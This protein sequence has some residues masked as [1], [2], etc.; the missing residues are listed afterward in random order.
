M[1]LEQREYTPEELGL[2]S[3]PQIEQREYTPEELGLPSVSQ[4]TGE[5]LLTT[6]LPEKPSGA[7]RRYLADPAL[8]LTKGIVGLGEAAV[9]IADIPTMGY[10]GK[11]F[12]KATEAIFGGTSK[13]LQNFLQS[14]KTPEQLAQEHEVAK[15]KGFFGTLGTL[16]QNPAAIVQILVGQSFP[17]MIRRYWSC[18]LCYS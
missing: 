6:Q 4:P 12:E 9:G 16:A 11:G 14:L 2:T 8:S 7:T 18:S 1:A 5:E 3:T 10:A 15:A 13:D 17:Q